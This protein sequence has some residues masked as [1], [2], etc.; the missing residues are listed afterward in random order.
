M[1][2]KNRVNKLESVC[3]THRAY[4]L[5]IIPKPG[6]TEEQ[7]TAR[8]L[9]ANSLRSLDE[10]GVAVFIMHFGPGYE[11][12]RSEQKQISNRDRKSG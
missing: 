12:L 6:E 8:T 4:F 2:I 5:A 9:K 7:A 3:G 1:T 11:N 10:V